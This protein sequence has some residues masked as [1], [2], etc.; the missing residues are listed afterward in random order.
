MLQW[1]GLSSTALWWIAIASA[2]TFVSGIFAVPWFVVRIPADY[3]AHSDR[4][5][6]AYPRKHAWFRWMWLIGKNLLGIG[7]L[8]LGAMMLVLPGQGILTLVIAFMLLDF[9]GKFRLQRWIVSRKGVLDSINWM[10]KRMNEEPL[11]LD[12]HC[13]TDQS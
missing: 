11:L 12:K 4:N 3:F 8:F 7:F 9:P 5:D 10:R 6:A 2:I 1:I 13:D